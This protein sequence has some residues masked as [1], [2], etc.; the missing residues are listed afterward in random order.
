[1]VTLFVE[2]VLFTGFIYPARTK[3]MTFA[4]A[5]NGG[6]FKIGQRFYESSTLKLTI[7]YQGL[8]IPDG[9]AK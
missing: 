2:K 5:V 9:S 3:R 4:D 6:W 1:M 7:E 8:I